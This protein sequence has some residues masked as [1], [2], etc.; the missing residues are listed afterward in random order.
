MHSAKASGPMVLLDGAAF[1]SRPRIFIRAVTADVE[2]NMCFQG[3]EGFGS[4]G[5]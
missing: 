2:R 3:S 5:L 4:C 1:I